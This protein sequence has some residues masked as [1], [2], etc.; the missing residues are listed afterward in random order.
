[1]VTDTQRHSVNYIPLF[2][3]ALNSLRVNVYKQEGL[4]ANVLTVS[5]LFQWNEAAGAK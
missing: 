2:S 4:L 3:C 5:S 1:M